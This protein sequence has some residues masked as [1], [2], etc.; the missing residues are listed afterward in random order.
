MQH[1]LSDRRWKTNRHTFTQLKDPHYKLYPN[2]KIVQLSVTTETDLKDYWIRPIEIV[3]E[4]HVLY[5]IDGKTLYTCL[6]IWQNYNLIGACLPL[7][8]GDPVSEDVT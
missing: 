3:E 8:R 6:Q 7:I 2:E 4:L 1:T 5:Y